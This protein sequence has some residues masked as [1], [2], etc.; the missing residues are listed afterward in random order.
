MA[1]QISTASGTLAA[2]V[3][4]TADFTLSDFGRATLVVSNTG[5]S[6]A[7]GTVAV[8]FSIDG[9]TTYAADAAVGTAVGSIAAGAS[10][11]IELEGFGA[12][13]VRVT[14]TS[15]S[16]S[17]YAITFRAT[18]KGASL[19]R[20][21]RVNGTPVGVQTAGALSVTTLAASGASTLSGAVTAGSTIAA[22]GDIS[23]AG[24]FR[25][26]V[27]PFYVTTAADQTAVGTK[28]GDTVGLAWVAPRAG[29]VMG[30]SGALDTAITGSDTTITARVYKNG[31]LLNAAFDLAFTEAGGE[32]SDY[33]TAAKDAHA[34]AAGDKLTVVYTSTTITNTPKL[35]AFLEV[36]C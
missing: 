20:A 25:Q 9:G 29:S 13:H 6:N 16:G 15:A 31:S 4:G 32:V 11:L 26:S 10:A 7:I 21:A 24:G 5:D 1:D 34:F 14:L 27:G 35:A 30:A 17:D 12:K 22:T 28:L 2:A 3:A 19:P 23:A 33:A 36:E 18:D 8:S